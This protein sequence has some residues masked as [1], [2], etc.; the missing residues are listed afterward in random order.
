[1]EHGHSDTKDMFDVVLFNSTG[2]IDLELESSSPCSPSEHSFDD[3]CVSDHDSENHDA[4]VDGD[5]SEYIDNSDSNSDTSDHCG[6]HCELCEGTGRDRFVWGIYDDQSNIS[7]TGDGDG[8][9]LMIYLRTPS[10]CESNELA[11]GDDMDWSDLFAEPQPEKHPEFPE[12][13]PQGP[14]GCE[15]EH[16]VSMLIT[17]EWRPIRSFSHDLHHRASCVTCSRYRR[18]TCIE[19]GCEVRDMFP[20]YSDFSDSD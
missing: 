19:C 15:Y 6:S 7:D 12:S 17:S 10:E 20:N 16:R 13:S 11:M 8:H 2:V 18:G 4:S 3:S 5:E 14:E 1:M 9:Q